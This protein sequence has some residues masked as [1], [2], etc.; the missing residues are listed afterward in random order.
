MSFIFPQKIL[1]RHCDPA[2]MVFYPRYFELINDCV[3]A[4]FEQVLD[5]PY[6][7][8]HEQNAIPTVEITTQF[9]APSR[10]GDEVLIALDCTRLGRSSMAL[11]FHAKCG[12][13]TR[14]EAR[15]TL[16]FVD[17]SGRPTGWPDQVRQKLDQESK[18]AT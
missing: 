9:K 17:R 18:G 16:V 2:G 1:F 7:K 10:L 3:E 4:F 5:L 11:G 15:S 12:D 13:E 14:F 6:D 8:L